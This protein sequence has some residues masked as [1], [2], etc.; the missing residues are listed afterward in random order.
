MYNIYCLQLYSFA[1]ESKRGNKKAVVIQIS[2]YRIYSKYSDRHAWSNSVDQDQT[3]RFAA[4]D[5]GLHCLLRIQH[6]LTQS[7]H[8][9]MV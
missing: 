4:S 7:S 6:I 9:F 5:L 2:A 8:I 1:K 3:P